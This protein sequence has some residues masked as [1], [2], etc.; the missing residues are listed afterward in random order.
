ML[1]IAICDD[2]VEMRDTVEKYLYHIE[3]KWNQEFEIKQFSS[4]ESLCENL[5]NN[6]YDV[7]LL[8]ILMGSGIDGVDT[9]KKICEMNVKSYVIFI[10]SFDKRVKELF[11]V[12]ALAFLDKPL[13]IEQLEINLKKVY[14]FLEKESDN[15]F[16]YTFNKVQSFVYLADIIFIESKR[17]KI[18][19]H[20]TKEVVIVNETMKD[21]W[22]KLQTKDYFLMLN[23]SCIVSL[24]YAKMINPSTFYIHNDN[25][26]VT[27]GRTMKDDVK[28]R[29]IKFIRR[30]EL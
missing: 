24:K 20:T 11:G 18:E 25:M 6:R 7:I 28:Q 23:R 14:D 16:V 30:T 2:E 26:E 27:V 8:D 3:E 17:Q 1:R 21:I 4:G 13:E 5:E 9:A 10:S 22:N 29:Y 12:R 15:V 19:I